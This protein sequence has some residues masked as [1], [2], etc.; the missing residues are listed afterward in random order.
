MYCHCY[1]PKNPIVMQR[2]YKETLKQIKS[3]ASRGEVI[4]GAPYKVG[5]P[6]SGDMVS[7]FFLGDTW[8]ILPQ[9]PSLRF[10]APT[11]SIISIASILPSL[12]GVTVE[13]IVGTLGQPEGI[14]E[15]N[16]NLLYRR[17]S[18]EL[19]NYSLQIL[20]PT[21]VGDAPIVIVSRGM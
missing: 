1:Y 4:N 20:L 13:D 18:Y 3:F 15:P 12:K 7:V 8:K 9:Y 2:S 19:V 5:D 16:T 11:D 6:I 10:F 14:L 21:R 17:V